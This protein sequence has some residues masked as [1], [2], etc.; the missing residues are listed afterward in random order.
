MKLFNL[1]KKKEKEM[2][3]FW[4]A[5]VKEKVAQQEAEAIMDKKERYNRYKY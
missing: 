3:K 5:E 4:K 2:R 1:F